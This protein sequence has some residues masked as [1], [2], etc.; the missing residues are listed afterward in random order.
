MNDH[1]RKKHS[2]TRTTECNSYFAK[3]KILKLYNPSQ[4]KINL[5]MQIDTEFS[6]THTF[7][8]QKEKEKGKIVAP[9]E[10]AHFVIHPVAFILTAHNTRILRCEHASHQNIRFAANVMLSQDKK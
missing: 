2:I 3:S 8:Q 4:Q 10:S 7:P 5:I 6:K 1:G 9:I